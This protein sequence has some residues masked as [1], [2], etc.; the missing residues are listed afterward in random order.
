MLNRRGHVPTLMLFVVAL[1]LCVAAWFSFLTFNGDIREKAAS[2]QSWNERVEAERVY[3]E[4][5][6][7]GLVAGAA[8]DAS[9]ALAASVE[10]GEG[11]ETRFDR[12]LQVRVARFSDVKNISGN[13]LGLMRTHSYLLK[14]DGEVYV[15]ELKNIFLKIED[16]G[17]SVVQRFDMRI[18]FMPSG[19]I[20]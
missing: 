16:G 14:Q 4:R 20:R 1:A 7:E 8:R 19:E 18:S 15:F 3:A 12:F 5:V 13:A 11:Y 6:I 9:E 17:N 10:D 2:L